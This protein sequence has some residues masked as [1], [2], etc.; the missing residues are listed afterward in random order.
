M[1]D[2]ADIFYRGKLPSRKCLFCAPN[3]GMTVLEL[4]NF[5]LIA[6]TYPIVPGHLMISS[7]QH[8][9]SAGEL[10]PEFHAEL[11]ECKKIA[12]EWACSLG[13]GCIFYEHGKA[14]SCHAPSH[15]EI[16]CEHFHLHCLPV[17][18]CIHAGIEARFP[19]MMLAKYEDL[20]EHYRKYGSYLFF[21]NSEGKMA[22]YPAQSDKVPSHFLRTLLCETLSIGS[23]SDWASYTD[24]TRYME[25]RN[26]I[27]KMQEETYVLL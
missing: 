27:A 12:K 13:H 25:S 19:G 6:D 23:F 9:G 2:Y 15:G 11:L 10:L 17:S 1:N 21:E 5:R 8:Y 24:V 7:K 14:G 22:F 3:A 16:H 18:V 20:F 4:E 26:V